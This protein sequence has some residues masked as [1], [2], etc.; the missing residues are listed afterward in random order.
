MKRCTKCGIEKPENEFHKDKYSPTG[1]SYKCKACVHEYNV[2]HREQRKAYDKLRHENNRDAIKIRQHN[3]HLEHS[4]FVESLKTSCDKCGE[5]RAYVI[6][7]HHINPST[8]EF[9]IGASKQWGKERLENEAK[10]C[11]CLCKNCHAEF[12]YLYGKQ[13][14]EPVKALSEYLGVDEN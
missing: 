1:L 5:N 14:E 11:V 7:F 9:T 13:P 3:R 10:K 4:R 6:E 2:E 8:K 12:H